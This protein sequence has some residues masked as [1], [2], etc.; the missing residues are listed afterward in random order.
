MSSVALNVKLGM[1]GCSEDEFCRKIP[2]KIS[3]TYVYVPTVVFTFIEIDNR[4]LAD[5]T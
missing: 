3:L 5:K 4:H 2:V 1:R